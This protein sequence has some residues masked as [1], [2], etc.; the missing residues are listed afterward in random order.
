MTFINEEGMER[1]LRCH[2]FFKS[3]KI[4]CV[5]LHLCKNTH[6]YVCY[7]CTHVG[8]SIHLVD[9]GIISNVNSKQCLPPGAGLG[10]FV[11]VF[12]FC[13]YFIHF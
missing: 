8:V 10:F 3:C 13:F 5:V 6:I 2:V 9:L 1:S 4:I 7:V 12:V 11:L